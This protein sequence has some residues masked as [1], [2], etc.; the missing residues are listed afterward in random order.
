MN[1]LKMSSSCS[2]V[3]VTNSRTRPSSWTQLNCVK[4]QTLFLENYL[5][6]FCLCS[7]LEACI[8]TKTSS[9]RGIAISVVNEDGTGEGSGLKSYTNTD[10]QRK[11]PRDPD[12]LRLLPSLSIIP[13]RQNQLIPLLRCSKC[14]NYRLELSA[15]EK[16]R[17]LCIRPHWEL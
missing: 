16:T 17:F 12:A 6:T 10:C 4:V 15:L 5:N 1:P 11:F 13:S 3:E 7:R 14:H 8:S 2:A 9:P